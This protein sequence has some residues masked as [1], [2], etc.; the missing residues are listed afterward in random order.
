VNGGDGLDYSLLNES[1]N[2]LNSYKDETKQEGGREK[3]DLE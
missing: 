2:I 3:D 1:R